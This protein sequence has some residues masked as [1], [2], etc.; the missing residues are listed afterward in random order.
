M[1]IFSSK[2]PFASWMFDCDRGFPAATSSAAAATAAMLSVRPTTE[3]TLDAEVVVES[4]ATSGVA[5]V[6]GVG[7][8][9]S[10][11][12]ALGL[13]GELAR[14][15]LGQQE[16]CLMSDYLRDLAETFGVN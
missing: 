11:R 1:G 10:A 14:F 4:S 5:N 9:N 16:L 8:E 13:F 7:K 3:R 6:L 12:S 2:P 15:C